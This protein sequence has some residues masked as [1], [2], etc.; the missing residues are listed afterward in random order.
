MRLSIIVP[1]YKVETYLQEC[2]DSILAQ[3]YTD[4]ELILVDDG[5]P[6]R[7]GEICDKYADQDSRIRVIHR[8]NGGLSAARNTG[9][10][11][12]EGD[13]I[14]FVDSDDF[15]GKDFYKRAMCLIEKG[16]E[17]IDIVEMPVEIHFN[18]KH[19]KRLYGNLSK[20]DI[21]KTSPDTIATWMKMNG[22]AH[23]YAWNKIYRRSLFDYF[24]F[25]E[26]RLFEDIHTVP[27]LMTKGRRI[28]FCGN[29]TSDERYYYRYRENSITTTAKYKA[30]HD[31]LEHHQ[32]T[33]KEVN[34]PIYQVPKVC[35]DYYFLQVTNL[36][37]ELLRSKG[38]SIHKEEKSSFEQGIYNLLSRYQPRGIETIHACK[39]LREVIKNIP[40]SL[41]GL[42]IHCFCYSG[43]W[44]KNTNNNEQP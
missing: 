29:S 33:L 37:I 42:K 28:A 16:N 15:I 26:G 1:V 43:R 20:K 9:I 31:A 12:S 23:T 41:F 32:W 25:P 35:L 4:F 39:G 6:D 24:R 3:S 2:I 11:A 5:S 14:T 38:E 17:L 21:I 7:C 18:I 19:K 8:E 13:F 34:K 40:L 36:L 27:R 22:T 44:I 30:L 10:N